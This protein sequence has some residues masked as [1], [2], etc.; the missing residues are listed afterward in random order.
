MFDYIYTRIK[1]IS[2][3]EILKNPELDFVTSVNLTTGELISGNKERKRG[4]VRFPKT[5]KKAGLGAL[6]VK[7]TND[8]HINLEGSLHEY[9]HGNNFCQ[10]S[11]DELSRVVS[12]IEGALQTDA[13][14]IILHNLEFG[15]NISPPFPVA[16]FL[17][18][19]LHYKGREPDRYTYDGRG[20]MRKFTFQQYEVKFYDKS[21]QYQIPGNI[22]RVEVKVTRMEFLHRRIELRTLRDLLRCEFYP[23]LKDILL[24][25]VEGLI[26]AENALEKDGLRVSDRNFLKM[27]DGRRFWTR[28]FSE[29]SRKYWKKA[30]KFRELMDRAGAVK[31]RLRI[32]ELVSSTWSRLS[33]T[34]NDL[35]DQ[36][37]NDLTN[38]RKEEGGQFNTYTNGLNDTYPHKPTDS[39]S[40]KCKTCGRDISDQRPGSI[41]CSESRYGRDAKRCRNRDSNPRNNF[42]KREKKIQER[43][44]LFD[45]TPYLNSHYLERLAC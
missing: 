25:I 19:I 21:A 23:A 34:R 1:G 37:G 20:N 32:L 15:V 35:T 16:E 36:R 44:L 31:V 7:V 6:T 9:C 11:R 3:G 29:N 27:A 43:G 10:F 45:I 40:R 12:Q 28:L 30:K 41:F 33:E 17:D 42:L 14:N 38:Q 26:V 39:D 8:E 4:G 22:L 2:P 13:G 24:E 18:G 5:V